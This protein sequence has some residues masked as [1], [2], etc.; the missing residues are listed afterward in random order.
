MKTDV[1]NLGQK[2]KRYIKFPGQADREFVWLWRYQ[3]DT[4]VQLL[5]M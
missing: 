5:Q 4:G 1:L 2:I 3:R